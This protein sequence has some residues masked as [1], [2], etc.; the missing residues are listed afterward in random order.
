MG[1]MKHY[2]A[3]F[4]NFTRWMKDV[5]KSGAADTSILEG[6]GQLSEVKI[7]NRLE[8]SPA[9]VVSGKYGYSANMERIINAQIGS[10]AQV[11][12]FSE[13]TLELNPRHPIIVALKTQ[14]EL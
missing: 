12:Q 3:K 8:S 10:K 2:T 14:Y 4:K 13:R 1:V 5:I 7:S 9:V 11:Q 6:N